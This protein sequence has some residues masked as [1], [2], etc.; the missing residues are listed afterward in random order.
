MTSN[1]PI[2]IFAAVE[3][4]ERRAIAIGAELLSRS[5]AGVRPDRSQPINLAI[6]HPRH[7]PGGDSPPHIIVTSMLC[8]VEGAFEDEALIRERRSRGDG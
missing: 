8:E 4:S 6:G 7:E 1:E 3:Q 2:R 5:I